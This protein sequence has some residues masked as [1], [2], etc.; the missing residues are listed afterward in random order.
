MSVRFKLR[1]FINNFIYTYS[2]K[3]RGNKTVPNLQSKMWLMPVTLSWFGKFNLKSEEIN[4][5][6]YH[7][8]I[9]AKYILSKSFCL[10]IFCPS[11]P[12]HRR[13]DLLLIEGHWTV[14]DT[15]KCTSLA[16]LPF[17]RDLQLNLK[18]KPLNTTLHSQ[19]EVMGG[20]GGRIEKGATCNELHSASDKNVSVVVGKQ[21]QSAPITTW[22]PH[23]RY[24]LDKQGKLKRSFLLLP[25]TCRCVPHANTRTC[26]RSG[27]ET[28]SVKSKPND[29][30]ISVNTECMFYLRTFSSRRWQQHSESGTDRL[31]LWHDKPSFLSPPGH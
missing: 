21:P 27:V 31:S 19:E 17:F 29:Y 9:K 24:T 4:T 18:A 20:G 16:T 28:R 1:A 7:L 30:P 23:H 6:N 15:Q 8:L 2:S 10:K 22:L 5:I 14:L 26:T 13:C 3:T 11:S 25:S 12:Y